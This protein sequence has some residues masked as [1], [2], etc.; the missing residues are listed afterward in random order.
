MTIEE[1][2]ANNFGSIV[3][4]SVAVI[5]SCITGFVS[6]WVS[7]A[8]HERTA[9]KEKKAVL[10]ARIET[11][12]KEVVRWRNAISFYIV[13]VENNLKS[14]NAVL[15]APDDFLKQHGLVLSDIKNDDLFISIKLCANDKI[16]EK[17]N[18]VF[19]SYM[20][21]LGFLLSYSIDSEASALIEIKIGLF[22]N[23]N[24]LLETIDAEIK[25]LIN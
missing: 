13:H 12:L 3:T 4:G 10:L 24:K 15:S 21:L 23:L 18:D 14:K 6:I 8:N 22:A 19:I 25:V 16:G 17:Y 5:A 11:A 7:R 9:E 2:I 1:A 20:S